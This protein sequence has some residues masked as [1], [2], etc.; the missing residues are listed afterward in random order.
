MTKTADMEAAV[1][2]VTGLIEAKLRAHEKNLGVEPANIRPAPASAPAA[3]PPNG[4][5]GAQPPAAG[6]V[7]QPKTKAE[8]DALPKGTPYI[9]PTL[10]PKVK[11]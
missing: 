11:Q 8:Y 10:G 2:K 4:P 1:D 3:A 6:A 5:A 7:A 9:H